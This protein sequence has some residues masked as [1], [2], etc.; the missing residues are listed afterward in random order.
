MTGEVATRV[1]S[2]VAPRS[3][4]FV[5]MSLGFLAVAL[6]GFS[7]TFFIPLARGTFVAPPVIYVHGT[8]LFAW[9]IF[10]IAQASL[11]RVRSVLMHRRLGWFGA[12]LG[13]AIVISGVAVALYVTRRGLAAGRGDIVLREFLGLL[14]TLLTF[15][16]LVAAAVVLRRNSASHKRLLLLATI[17]ILAPAWVRFRH[18]FPAVEN[19]FI[20]FT[21]VADSVIV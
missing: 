8:L 16:S 18:L 9:L 4:F 7:T 12:L 10:F 5:Y 14:V 2:K 19:P 17:Y 11:I 21:F 15:G 6:I 13:V 20:V 1:V 3:G